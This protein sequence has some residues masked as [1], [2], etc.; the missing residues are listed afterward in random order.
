VEPLWLPLVLL[1]PLIEPLLDLEP[2]LM[3]DESEPLEEPLDEPLSED[4][5]PITP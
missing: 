4:A 3:L 1:E 2:V 5:Q